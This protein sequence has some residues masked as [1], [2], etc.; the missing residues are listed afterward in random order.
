MI[1]ADDKYLGTMLIYN[2]SKDIY[3]AYWRELENDFVNGTD[4]YPANL[5]EAYENLNNW[6]PP[7]KHRGFGRGANDE[8]EEMSFAQR[9][10][11]E[12]EKGGGG[13]KRNRP[14]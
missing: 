5:V 4:R 2:A 8:F 7:E 11:L 6:V 1:S 10:Q 13:R 12:K 9:L 14:L 3:S